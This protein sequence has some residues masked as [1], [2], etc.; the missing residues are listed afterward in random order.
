MWKFFKSFYTMSIIGKKSKKFA[1]EIINLYKHLTEH[2]KE[3]ILSKQILKSG[4]SIGA[5]VKEASFA[6]SRADFYSKMYIAYKEAGETE[7]WLELLY[8]SGFIKKDDY[9]K[10]SAN[11]QE[12]IKILSS[13]TKNQKEENTSTSNF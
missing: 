5:N 7:Y 2:K 8:E 3:F 12:I 10:L 6:Q 11:C 9:L 13:I 1:L 4:T